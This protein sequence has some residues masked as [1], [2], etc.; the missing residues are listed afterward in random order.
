M[1]ARRQV[2]CTHWLWE[3][4]NPQT[5]NKDLKGYELTILVT[6]DGVFESVHVDDIETPPET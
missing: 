5:G 1:I 2:R 4:L 3:K 6:K